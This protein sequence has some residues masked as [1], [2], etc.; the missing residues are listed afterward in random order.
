MFKWS[1]TA[2]SIMWLCGWFVSEMSM[3]SYFYISEI[4]INNIL[5]FNWH[6][7]FSS[8]EVLKLMVCLRFDGMHYLKSFKLLLAR[9]ELKKESTIGA[10]SVYA[11]GSKDCMWNWSRAQ[12]LVLIHKW[13]HT[14]EY[15]QIRNSQRDFQGLSKRSALPGTQR[16]DSLKK[17]F[18]FLNYPLVRE[19]VAHL[20]LLWP[21]KQVKVKTHSVNTRAFS[22]WGHRGTSLYSISVWLA[23]LSSHAP[24]RL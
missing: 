4:R 14:L 18:F 16:W 7:F 21:L 11:S 9:P 6:F 13:P 3:F 17:K 5:E 20:L 19:T 24:Q 23:G 12:V 8:L 22:V 10:D 15:E 1:Q 2:S